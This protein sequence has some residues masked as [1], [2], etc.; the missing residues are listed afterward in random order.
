MGMIGA[1]R[2]GVASNIDQIAPPN[3]WSAIVCI[4]LRDS[5]STACHKCMAIS[6]SR[7]QCHRLIVGLGTLRRAEYPRN[8]LSINR[9]E[10]A[11]S[12]ATITCKHDHQ[13]CSPLMYMY[14]NK[15]VKYV[16]LLYLVY[17]NRLGHAAHIK[18]LACPSCQLARSGV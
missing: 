15:I 16:D 3:F 14:T 8:S 13:I 4:R 11:P 2:Q 1:R 9:C 12:S 6:L 18:Q 17:N 5:Q 10:I 7:P